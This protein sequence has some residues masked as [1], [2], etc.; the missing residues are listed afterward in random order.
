[1]RVVASKQPPGCAAAEAQDWV[2]AIFRDTTRGI[3]RALGNAL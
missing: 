2:V 1:L 3:F